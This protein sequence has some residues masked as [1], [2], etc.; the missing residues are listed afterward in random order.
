MQNRGRVA[1][2]TIINSN[3][4]CGYDGLVDLGYGRFKVDHS[5][6]EFANGAVR[7]NGSFRGSA[8]VRLTKFDSLSKR[9]FHMHPKEIEW[10]YN[11]RH[12]DRRQILLK[13]LR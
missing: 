10:R 12:V 3:S 1:P 8:R 2:S 7:T 11:H 4:W 13:C 5:K 6:N 9:T